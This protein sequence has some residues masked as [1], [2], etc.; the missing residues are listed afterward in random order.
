MPCTLRP[1]CPAD[2]AAIHELVRLAFAQAEHSD[3]DE[4]HLVDRLRRSQEYLPELS[5]VAEE[6]GQLVGHIMFTRLSI[7]GVAAL[8]LAPVSVLPTHQG[9][10][11]GSALIRHGHAVA[12]D[13]GWHFV[14]VLG[15]AGYYPRFG[16]KP[17]SL[18]G[19]RPPFDVPDDVFMAVNLGSG[20]DLLPGLAS[21]SPAFF[22][23]ATE[24]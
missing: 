13:L 6:D 22:A 15:H 23:A 17:A 10:G 8:A 11:L 7:D 14:V 20:P 2:H 24:A 19:I 5:L 12:R 3:G 4:H 18:F 16:Y 9:K 1:E 21:Y